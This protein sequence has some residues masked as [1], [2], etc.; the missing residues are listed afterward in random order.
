ME[1]NFVEI[2]VDRFQEIWEY[3][4]SMSVFSWVLVLSPLVVLGVIW[5]VSN[6]RTSLSS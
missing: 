1:R 5:Y 4:Q 6:R 2:V 3:A